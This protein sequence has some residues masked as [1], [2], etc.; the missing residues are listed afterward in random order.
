MSNVLTAAGQIKVF[1]DS[2]IEE[3]AANY[4]LK[5]LGK[6]PID[7]SLAKV[8]D[9]GQMSCLRA[10]GWRERQTCWKKCSSRQVYQLS[11]GQMHGVTAAL[12]FFLCRHD[13]HHCQRRQGLGM[14]KER[15]HLWTN[16][17]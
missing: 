10:T 1:G 5:V 12:P 9:N 4:D 15:M 16:K 7:P 14:L 11:K 6:L 8:C 17:M 13:R 3:I 2:H